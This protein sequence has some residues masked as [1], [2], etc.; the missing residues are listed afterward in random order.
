LAFH[1]ELPNSALAQGAD[2]T[3]QSTHKT[4]GALTQASM[5]H[6]QGHRIDLERL[7]K[8]LQLVQSTSPS[9]L[10]LASLDAARHQMAMSG[11]ALMSQ[12][13]QLAQMAKTQLAQ[14]PRLSLPL[15]QHHKSSGFVALDQTRLTVTVAELG[16]T[17]FAVEKI[18]S[19]K[20]GV[21][22]EFASLQHLTFILSLGNTQMDIERLVHS[23]NQLGE[24]TPPD[25]L[26]NVT[27]PKLPY[28]SDR[29]SEICISPK[30]AFFAK[31]ETLP[32][33]KAFG[34]ICAETICPYPPGIP[35]LMPGE[36]ITQQAGEYLQQIQSWGGFITGCADNTLQSVQV[37]KT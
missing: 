13:L 14:I 37:L 3:V 23:F 18:L 27:H 12:T 34:R 22:P 6:I 10:L 21:I 11:F 5:L 26:A 7:R 2:L 33:A 24:I 4:L 28:Q 1:P 8:S 32:L 31:S 17:G 15:T 30:A 16:L 20:F 29:H 35:I 19:E 36:M 25:N 9:Y